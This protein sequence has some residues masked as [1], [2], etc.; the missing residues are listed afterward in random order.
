MKKAASIF[1]LAILC[2]LTGMTVVSS[3]IPGQSSNGRVGSPN[4]T[5]TWDPLRLGIAAVGALGFAAAVGALVLV[6]KQPPRRYTGDRSRLAFKLLG[7]VV[8]LSLLGLGVG[9]AGLL[10]GELIYPTWSHSGFF[11][12]DHLPSC[13]LALAAPGGLGALSEVLP[14]H[15]L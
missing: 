11:R 14:K 9:G 7:V 5:Y 3:L 15:R 2:A 8:G 6:F 1:G 13:I 10:V 12:A 4:I